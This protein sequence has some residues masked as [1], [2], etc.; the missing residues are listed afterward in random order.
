MKELKVEKFPSRTK[1]FAV[2]LVDKKG[3]KIIYHTD[4]ARLSALVKAAASSDSLP[5]LSLHAPIL[6]D[7]LAVCQTLLEGP[8]FSA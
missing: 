7:S 8:V 4:E 6:I 2:V 1:G 3:E 5:A